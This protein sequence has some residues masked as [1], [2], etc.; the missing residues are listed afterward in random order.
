MELLEQHFE[1]AFA[2]P[3]GIKKL[4]ELILTLAIRGQLVPQ[5][6]S[7]P[8][9]SE[10]LKEIEAE[11]KR[12]VKEGKIKAPKPL[13][14][15]TEE[16]KPYALPEG[17]EWVRFP[18][19]YY[20]I[21]NKFNQIQTSGYQESG[22]YPVV[23]Q[24]KAFIAAYTDEKER[25]LILEKPVIVF[26]DH[27]K[28]IKY[29]DFDFVI[30]ADGVKT[31]CPCDG[32]APKFLFRL[33]QSYS[34]MDRGYARHFGVLNEKLAPLPP[35]EEQQR[36]VA[37]IDEL[38][39]RCDALEKL[40]TEQEEKRLAV[41]AAA[42]TQ[43]LN[44]AQA[45]EHTRAQAFLSEHFGE[46]YTVKKNVAELRKAILQL[47]V[48]GKLVPQDPND[49]PASELLKEIEAEKKRLVK[50]GAIR[51]TRGRE[52]EK[53]LKANEMLTPLPQGWQ[54]VRLSSVFVTSS[55]NTFD[56]SLEKET[57]AFAYIKVGD[58]NLPGNEMVITTS[59]RFIDPDEK[60]CRALIPAGSIIFPKRGGAI[61]TNKKRIVR[62]QIFVDLNTMAITPIQGVVIN[63]AY[64]WLSTVDLA[65]LNTGTS[66]P[67]INHQDIDPLPFPL[68]PLSEQKRIV[69]KVDQL[70]ALCEALE[71]R[72]VAATGKQFELLNAVMAQV[73]DLPCA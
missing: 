28:N 5:D 20:G 39:A 59:S 38:M 14:L 17:W 65:T 52:A 3:D 58:M 67:Q 15:V 48:M 69:A 68:P 73:S 71:Q 64:L 26:G 2:A 27:T 50:E 22:I 49:P 70:M 25:L 7:D 54:W 29:I 44:I 31:L 8:P 34:L 4:R 16:E 13:P 63:Y 18:Y 32:I 6:P 9:A 61:A 43:L 62:N 57:G 30:G 41:H 66:V 60:M 55:G 24:G 72:I 42:I 37:K 45:D 36:I 56:A 1:T 40:R 46:L 11:K 12:L 23:D 51:G 21:G 19:C 53:E 33:M 10:L 47:A 35:L